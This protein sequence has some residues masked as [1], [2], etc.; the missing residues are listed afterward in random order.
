MKQTKTRW[1]TEN[2]DILF[3]ETIFECELPRKEEQ[4]IWHRGFFEITSILRNFDE[5]R[6]DVTLK[7]L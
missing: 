7:Q 3:E 2:D 5:N 4:V 6:I 1:I